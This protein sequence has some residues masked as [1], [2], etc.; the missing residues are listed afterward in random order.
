MESI[1]ACS[2]WLS[3]N[4]DVVRKSNS[5]IFICTC[6]PWCRLPQS[7]TKIRQPIWNERTPDLSC[8]VIAV[9][10]VNVRTAVIDC[11]FCNASY[12]LSH[13]SL[14]I[15]TAWRQSQSL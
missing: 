1:F 8:P 9:G 14:L 13:G 15:I 6:P 12:M 5:C 2:Q 3:F 11:N 7:E 4:H 10:G